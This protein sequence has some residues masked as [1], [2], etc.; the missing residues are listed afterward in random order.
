MTIRTLAAALPLLV[1]I[2]DLS[3]AAAAQAL[4]KSETLTL[5]LQDRATLPGSTLDVHFVGYHDSRCPTDVQCTW[6]GEATAFFWLIGG[7]LKPQILGVPWDGSGRPGLHTA[8][9]GRYRFYLQSLEPRP[10]HTVSIEPGTYRAVL[11]I[12]LPAH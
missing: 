4:D 11:T 8:R 7:G 10:N 12:S 3:T 1:A 5:K 9:A 6:S 2:P